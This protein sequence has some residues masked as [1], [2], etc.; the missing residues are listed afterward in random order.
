MYSQWENITP[1]GDLVEVVFV[2]SEVGY[3]FMNGS[4]YTDAQIYKTTDGGKRWFCVKNFGI[5]NGVEMSDVFLFNEDTFFVCCRGGVIIKTTD[6]G[7]SWDYFSIITEPDL[8]SIYFT[9]SSV[10][11]CAGKGGTILKT[12]N[13]GNTWYSLSTNTTLDIYKIFFPNSNVGYFMCGNNPTTFIFKTETSGLVWNQINEFTSN[14]MYDF[15]FSDSDTGCVFLGNSVKYTNDGGDSWSTTLNYSYAK[16]LGSLDSVLYVSTIDTIKLSYDKG[17]TWIP[18]LKTS[19][20]YMIDTTNFM[21]GMYLSNDQGLNYV[22][23]YS[24]L[25]DL[26]YTCNFNSIEFINENIGFICA[27]KGYISKTINSGQCWTGYNNYQINYN[28]NDIH[29]IN[30][31]IGV[32]VGANSTILNTKD[33]GDTWA[34]CDN[35]GATDDLNSISFLNDSIGFIVGNNGRAFKTTDYGSTWLPV[36]FGLDVNILKI[37]F[38]SNEIGFLITE[39]KIYKTED[40][41]NSWEVLDFTISPISNYITDFFFKDLS[42]GILVTRYNI[43]KSTDGGDT[44][45]EVYDND[46]DYLI[47]FGTYHSDYFIFS[48]YYSDNSYFLLTKDFET[49]FIN[50][51]IPNTGGYPMKINPYKIA[52]SSENTAF[53][54]SLDNHQ[55]CKTNNASFENLQYINESSSVDNILNVYPNPTEKSIIVNYGSLSKG[56]VLKITD[57]F[58]QEVYSEVITNQ[59]T[60]IDLNLIG[61]KKGLYFVYLIDN[62]SNIVDVKKIILQ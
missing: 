8:Y 13:A 21:S 42:N 1:S 29:F 4:Q 36:S 43:Y 34:F 58:A 24:A 46:G 15:Y 16:F 11:Y 47:T 35:F 61:G 59:E 25:S 53:F 62:Y 30:D 37:E 9:S 48:C 10:G 6:G 40:S 7:Q 54:I 57:L 56:Y 27:D 20:T 2:D 44:W 23:V 50:D 18:W 60:T 41:G 32:C 19:A 33:V 55:L 49:W 28:L 14:S 52:F 39:K 51:N 17:L 45:L 5:G 12:E 22:N 31:S 3:A 38:C 26:V